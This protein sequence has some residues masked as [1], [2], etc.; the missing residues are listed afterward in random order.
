MLILF[1]GLKQASTRHQSCQSQHQGLNN[2]TTQQIKKGD[3]AVQR[4]SF[5]ISNMTTESGTFLG[6]EKTRLSNS[7]GKGRFS[8]GASSRDNWNQ[9][10]QNNFNSQ[11]QLV[12]SQGQIS[13]ALTAKPR[14]VFCASS[15]HSNN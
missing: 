8:L 7:K 11:G 1:S 10:E 4:H 13:W 14:G 5:T 12:C 6:R 15:C 9:L 2:S 3:L